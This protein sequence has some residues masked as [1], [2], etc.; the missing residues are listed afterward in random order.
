MKTRIATILSVTGVLFAGSAAALVNTQALSSHNAS[1]AS[2]VLETPST[3]APT[4]PGSTT[5]SVPNEPSTTGE[6]TSTTVTE[7]TTA[8]T[9]GTDGT[10][11]VGP[12]RASDS[13][14]QHSYRVG[15]AGEV[16]LNRSDYS[17]TI[18]SVTPYAG[19]T[20]VSAASTEPTAVSVTLRSATFEVTFV[21]SLRDDEIVTSIAAH[22]IGT[23]TTAPTSTSTTIHRGDDGRG[24]D[25][26][27][28]G[29]TPT[30]TRDRSHEDD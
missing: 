1:A 25:G 5:T 19:W 17:L 27:G 8:V 12:Q 22:R 18:V 4:D 2:S 20:T 16:V 21:A 24:D 28:G 30:T 7:Q 23:S 26:R 6:S 14:G 11:Q 13:S 3:A 10:P 9:S 15:D 29:T